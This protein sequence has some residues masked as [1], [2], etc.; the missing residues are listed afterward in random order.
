MASPPQK[1]RAPHTLKVK[2]PSWD[3]VEAFYDRKLRG[4]NQLSMRVPFLVDTGAQLVLALELPN[5]MVMAIDGE[6]TSAEPAADNKRSAIQLTLHGMTHEVRERLKALVADGRGGHAIGDREP[7]AES[8][9]PAE[10][11]VPMPADAPVDEPVEP[12]R[13]PRLEDVEAAE[14]EVFVALDAD[15]RR[16]REGAAHE[17]LGV[18]WDAEVDE[19]RRGY[20]GLTK[21]Y[22][23]D[24]FSKYQSRAIRHLAQ[25]VFIHVNKAYDRMRDAA[26]AA[27]AAIVAGPALLPHDGWLASFDDI[28]EEPKTPLPGPL[29]AHQ[30]SGQ[31]RLP[32]A[33]SQPPVAAPASAPAF[34]DAPA[35]VPAPAPAPAPA[36]EDAPAFEEPDAAP[37][38]RFSGGHSPEAPLSADS[39]FGDMD[40]GSRPDMT[41]PATPSSLDQSAAMMAEGGDLLDRG[42]SQEAQD[43]LAEALRLDPRNRSLR[44]LYHVASGKVL[45]EKGEPVQA[46]AQFE[47][48]LAHDRDCDRAQHAIDELRKTHDKPAGL[49]KRLF[50]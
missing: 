5:E 10:P 17:V 20:F 16:M 43:L 11:P 9:Q 23:P 42:S 27:G 31:I 15:L 46:T 37:S 41:L 12:P 30:S 1:P 14:K 21:R 29:P 39:L 35:P 26:V 48:A 8:S 6:V 28:G 32:R 44:A 13:V 50:K 7:A 49:F 45:L 40:L 22:H 2:C 38:V 33:P 19:I 4:R 25:E 3:H 18:K 36:S 24:I 47:A 34:E